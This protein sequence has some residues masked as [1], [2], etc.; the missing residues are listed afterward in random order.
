MS[1][2][3][4]LGPEQ[5]DMIVSLPYRVGL[6]VSHA[7][8]AGGDEASEKELEA[9]SNIIQGFGADVFG[10]EAIQSIMNETVS[11][12]DKWDDWAHNYKNVPEDCKKAVYYLGQYGSDKDVT[13][14]QTYLMEIGE[15]VALA[16]RERDE[17]NSFFEEMHVHIVYWMSRLRA[18]LGSNVPARTI[19]D[20]LNV[21][22]RERRALQSLAAALGTRYQM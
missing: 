5:Q 3:D 19:D 13:M 12:R 17:E 14:F 9:L 20:F 1:F 2:L 18:M 15:A 7:D 6:W 4:S 22:H 16:F 21:S 10:S 8:S 11:R